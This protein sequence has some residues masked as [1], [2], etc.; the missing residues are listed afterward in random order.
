MPGDLARIGR[1]HATVEDVEALWQASRQA[2]DRIE[3]VAE[4]VA[5][6][7]GLV[8]WLIVAMPGQKVSRD[9]GARLADVDEARAL[10]ALREEED[11]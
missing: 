8:E 5:I 10:V 11:L 2:T 4:A 3:D 7:A 6:M 9:R 1:Q